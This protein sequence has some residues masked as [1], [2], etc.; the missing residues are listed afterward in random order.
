MNRDT[1]VRID[2]QLVT[3][4]KHIA[5]NHN[6]TLKQILE[7]LMKQFAKKE[8]KSIKEKNPLLY[9]VI[10]A[11]EVEP[12]ADE[13]KDIESEKRMRGK[14]KTFSLDEIRKEL[15]LK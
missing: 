1:T 3:L 5:L 10:M 2:K 15:E 14:E 7:D 4:M 11:E 8:I 12:T 13:I 6:T 9:A